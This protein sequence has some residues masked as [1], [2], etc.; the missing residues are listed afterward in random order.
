MMLQLYSSKL[1]CKKSQQQ[2][3]FSFIEAVMETIATLTISS[4][5][6]EEKL[7]ELL[8]CK[9]RDDTAVV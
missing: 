8:K 6:H 1:F 9:M 5:V 2:K 3:Q 7:F 4:T